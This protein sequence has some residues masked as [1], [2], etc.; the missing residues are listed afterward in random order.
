ML[1]LCNNAIKFTEK[2]EVELA[3]HCLSSTEDE[4]V[5][6]FSVRDTGIG[7]TPEVVQ[8]LFRSS[9]GRQTTTRRFGG[10][11]LGWPSASTWPS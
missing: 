11:G 9:P 10:T 7:M 2:G 8:R 5:L 4:M 3:F 6:H 1:N